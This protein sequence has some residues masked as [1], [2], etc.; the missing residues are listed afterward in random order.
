M[1]SRVVRC[2]CPHCSQWVV[3]VANSLGPNIC[4]HCFR[5]FEMPRPR[6]MPLWI[7]GVVVVLAAN[8]VLY[9]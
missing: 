8:L 5:F 9:I 2:H 4:P 7:W 3:Q 6:R 1:R